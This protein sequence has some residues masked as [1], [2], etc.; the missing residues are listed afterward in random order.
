[1]P[2]CALSAARPSSCLT[3]TYLRHRLTGGWSVSLTLSVNE[4]GYDDKSR[5]PKSPKSQPGVHASG[6]PDEPTAGSPDPGRGGVPVHSPVP[7]VPLA[8]AG[9]GWPAAGRGPG[10]GSE[11]GGG[12]P[13]VAGSRAGLQAAE[14]GAQ[15][16]ETSDP[17]R[18]RATRDVFAFLE[19][20]RI[21]FPV[22]LMCT[23]FG[24]IRSEF[25]AWRK[26]RPSDELNWVRIELGQVPYL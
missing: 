15:T 18:P 26:R 19:A 25:Y 22:S 4:R 24:V 1:M 5:S 12:T 11:G 6:G 10:P 14:D 20:N 8:Q 2:Q 9:S 16:V 23:R 21:S 7:A 17:V 13:A 3:L